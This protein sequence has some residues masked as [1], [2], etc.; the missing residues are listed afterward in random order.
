MKK[1]IMCMIL[2]SVMLLAI[3]CGGESKSS[4]TLD[5]FKS[6]YEAEEIDIT[7]EEQPLFS[8]IGAVDGIM[9]YIDNEK[10]AIYEYD[11]NKD[12]KDSEFEFDSVNGKFGLESKNEQA[13]TIFDSVE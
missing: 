8:A 7:E 3:G 2:V 6:A 9:F 12:L 13:K 10:V 4:L 11:S 1:V 5:S